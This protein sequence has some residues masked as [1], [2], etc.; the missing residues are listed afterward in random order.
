[1]CLL[2]FRD[3]NGDCDGFT[4]SSTVTLSSECVGSNHEADECAVVVIVSSIFL[5]F[6]RLLFDS[7]GLDIDKDENEGF[8][9]GSTVKLVS[10]QVTA[11]ARSTCDVD[12]CSV[13]VFAS[14]IAS[15]V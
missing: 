11:C 13:L 5:S 15:F 7:N 1:M 12:E 10:K 14:S 6:V 9:C 3:V 8:A 2:G 4:G